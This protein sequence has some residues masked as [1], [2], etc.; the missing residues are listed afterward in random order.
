MPS[1]SSRRRALVRA[2]GTTKTPVAETARAMTAT[3]TV[4]RG[5]SAKRW[6]GD[7]GT[8]KSVNIP[9][10]E[11]SSNA[12]KA[13]STEA[14]TPHIGREPPLIEGHGVLLRHGRLTA[15]GCRTSPA[16]MAACRCSSRGSRRSMTSD[17]GLH[18][19]HQW[20]SPSHRHRIFPAPAGEVDGL[21]LKI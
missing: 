10:K 17:V 12:R 3:P 9:E 11:S 15:P 19:P 2:A 14:S 4:N 16:T 6:S 7:S 8:P 1:R 20:L 5:A 13:K 18:D 21:V